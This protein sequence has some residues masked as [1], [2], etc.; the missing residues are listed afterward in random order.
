MVSCN[1]QKTVS[2]THAKSKLKPDNFMV[3][4]LQ[5]EHSDF[6][7]A[8][9][10]VITSQKGLRS[11]Y[12]KINKTRKPGLPLPEVDFAKEMLIIHCSGEQNGVGLAA[13]SF[14]EETQSEIIL[15]SKF[16]STTKVAVMIKTNPFCVYKIPVSDKA[17]VISKKLE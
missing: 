10:M 5:D 2:V 7:V 4:I 1:G 15:E 11:F 3:L 9:T 16:E 14:S 13:L 12:S 8:E 17:V 6:S